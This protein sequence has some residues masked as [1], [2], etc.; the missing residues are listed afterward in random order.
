M[1]L[2]S[3]KRASISKR[4][5]TGGRSESRVPVDRADEEAFW[6]KERGHNPTGIGQSPVPGRVEA[7]V[8]HRLSRA[9]ILNQPSGLFDRQRSLSMIGSAY[10]CR[11]EATIQLQMSIPYERP[12]AG[13]ATPTVHG[14]TRNTGGHRVATEVRQRPVRSDR[15]GRTCPV[16]TEAAAVPRGGRT[17]PGQAP[18]LYGPR[19]G[20]HTGI[21]DRAKWHVSFRV[22]RVH[23][24]STPHRL[25]VVGRPAGPVSLGTSSLRSSLCGRK[26]WGRAA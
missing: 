26:V 1:I 5:R 18:P 4:G 10:R 2:T 9:V 13:P 14:T 21:P 22:S 7:S 16:R 15:R 12:I 11:K 24:G 19:L 23:T 25:G 8:I 3:Q 17:S 6:R 20:K